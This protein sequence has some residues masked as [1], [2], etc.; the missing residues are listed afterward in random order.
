[1][2]ERHVDGRDASALF[3]FGSECYKRGIRKGANLVTLG[4]GLGMAVFGTLAFIGYL[5]EKNQK[6]ES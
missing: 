6:K 5:S 2:N 1:M 3:N 4:V